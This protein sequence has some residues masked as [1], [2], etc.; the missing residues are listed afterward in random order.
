MEKRKTTAIM[1]AFFLVMMSTT[2]FAEQDTA[3]INAEKFGIFTLIPPLLAIVLAFITKNVILSLFLGVLSGTIIAEISGYNIFS[4]V[5]R[6]FFGFISTALD[7]LADPWNAGIVLQVLTIGGLIALISKMGGARAVAEALAERAKT[8][9]SAQLITWV[10]GIIVF[11]DDYANSL[12][13][14]P[15]M[16]PVTDRMR[17]SR[18]KLAFIV[19]G[20]AAPIAGIALVSTWIGYELTLIR[21]GFELVGQEVNPYGIFLSTI[22]YR[23]YNIF[24]LAFILMTVFMSREF[25]SM[26]KAEKR[27]R[28]KGQVIRPGSKPMVSTELEALEP[29]KGIKYKVS[30]AVIPILVLMFGSLGGFYY[31]GYTSIME[32]TDEALANALS[33]SPVSFMAIRETFGAADASVVLFQAA[34]IASL[35]AIGMGVFQKIFRVTEAIDIWLEGLKSLMITG[36][37]LILAWSLSGVIKQLG[38]AVFLINILKNAPETVLQSLQFLLPGII[39]VL[40]SVISFATGTSYGTMGILMPLAIPLAFSLNPDQGYII[41]SVGAV[42]TGAIFGDHCC[43]I[44][45]TTILSSMGAA[46]DH[47]DHTRTQFEYALTV[48]GVSLLLGYILVGLGVPV[49]ISLILGIVALIIVL[50]LIGKRVDN[51][52]FEGMDN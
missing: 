2:V 15:I 19:D 32:G 30:N 39:F 8:A 31:N 18:E 36:V 35:V 25:G 48:A 16:R 40:G 45:D 41:M 5:V 4:A 6:G 28:S 34:L 13:V 24:M 1:I 46:C 21:D 51:I 14:G 50:R 11:F 37:I 3:A 44:S 10:L 27:S 43:P 22:P 47:I 20:T 38:T 23:F 9:K 12:I 26:Y 52:P 7:S 17:I 49:W 29:K 42:L 33:A